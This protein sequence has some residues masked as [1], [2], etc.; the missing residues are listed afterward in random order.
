[1]I[2]VFI[3]IAAFLDMFDF[4]IFSYSDT[5][6]GNTA[7]EFLSGPN[8]I[9][10]FVHVGGYVVALAIVMSKR[11]RETPW[12]TVAAVIAIVA[13]AAYRYNLT[14][15]GQ[16]PP[17]MPF[18]EDPSYAPTW[19]EGSVAAGIVAF[20]LLGYS[21]LTR[22]LPMEEPAGPLSDIKEV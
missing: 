17:L 4:I 22:I 11:G 9:F 8:L 20:V 12:L 16:A 18:L 10:S 1:M 19:V 21:L 13:V 7:W 5:I 14:I 15:V 6:T 2:G 3:A